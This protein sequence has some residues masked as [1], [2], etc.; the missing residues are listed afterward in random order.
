[1][2]RKGI[3]LLAMAAAILS[4]CSLG[5][6]G[7]GK[8]DRVPLPENV[9]SMAVLDREGV[10]LREHLEGDILR[11]LLQGMK[12]APSSY[13]GDPEQ[14]GEP[15]GLVV[16]GAKQ[17]RTFDI[18]DMGRTN[19]LDVSAKLYAALPGEE[20][21][22]AWELSTEWM[23][24]LL[25]PAA[26]KAEAELFA[27][28]EEDSDSVILTANRDIDA[29]SVREAIQGSL[30]IRSDAASSA[31]PEYK[32]T[33][34]R[35]IVVRFPD[36]PKGTQIQ[37]RLDEVKSKEGERFSVRSSQGDGKVTVRQGRAWSGLRWVD[38]DGQTVYEHG[39]DAAALIQI[40][41]D[42]AVEDRAVLIYN[43]DGT[44]YRLFPESRD[45]HDVTVQGWGDPEAKGYSDDGV[46]SLYSFPDATEAG[47]YVAQGLKTVYYVNPSNDTK[48][49]IYDS[50]SSIYGMAVSPD[51][52]HIAVLADSE[53]NL[54]PIADLTIVDAQG[55][56]GSTFPQA[57]YVGHSE[58]WHLIYPVEW[59]DADTVA[60]PLFGTPEFPSSRGKALFH[61]RQGLLS[62]EEAPVLP[63]AALALLQSE[64]GEAAAAQIVCT[65]PDPN[66]EQARDYVVSLSGIGSYLVGL[67]D[68]KVTRLGAGEPIMW[69]SDRQIVVWD[70]TEGKSVSV[71]GL[72]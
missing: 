41:R 35:R 1:M 27:T 45:I 42:S 52:R 5:G 2:A 40:A 37:L 70:S 3:L 49:S 22:R 50:E 63:E 60:V 16:R 43:R 18:Q 55:E 28:V 66:D 7:D 21:G 34:S 53:S 46:G 48:R 26:E 65:L 11:R 24:L 30:L 68:G 39:F 72:E 32:L 51:G 25:D 62:K 58:G 57:A 14:S 6:A 38:T 29:E 33:D 36:L 19:S 13:I 67:D 44:V 31:K 8:R 23:Q 56:T 10:V 64:L 61:Y 47:F 4:A 71:V 17:T 20:R 12:S 69:T 9:V 54:G 15:Y 59:I